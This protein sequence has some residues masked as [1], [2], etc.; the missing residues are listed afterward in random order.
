MHI[1]RK[2]SRM[3]E[4]F[5]QCHNFKIIRAF[6]FPK[7][8]LCITL[9]SQVTN[10]GQKRCLY[11]FTNWHPLDDQVWVFSG[12]IELWVSFAAHL[13]IINICNIFFYVQIQVALGFFLSK[14]L[15]KLVYIIWSAPKLNFQATFIFRNRKIYTFSKA[16]KLLRNFVLHELIL[17]KNHKC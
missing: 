4:I 6:V 12:N 5:N 17:L 16:I 11:Q 8:S 9:L 2:S 13:H 10:V 1:W 14:T 15:W 7:W 3:G